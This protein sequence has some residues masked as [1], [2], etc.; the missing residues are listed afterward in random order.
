MPRQYTQCILA[1][2]T[3][4]VYA[5]RRPGVAERPTPAPPGR[6]Q[7]LASE[8]PDFAAGPIGSAGMTVTLKEQRLGALRWIVLSGPG[9]E[10][11]GALGRHMR[12]EIRAVVTEWDYMARLRQ[13][14]AGQPAGGRLAT[15]SRASEAAFPETWA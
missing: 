6:S 15:V 5:R 10:A 13:H 1:V 7:G 3:L 4:S 2:N 12:A 11:F 9:T 8:L 14:V